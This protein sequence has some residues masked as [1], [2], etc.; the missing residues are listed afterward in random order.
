MSIYAKYS[1]AE[2]LDVLKLLNFDKFFIQNYRD[3]S[4]MENNF[5]FINF[6]I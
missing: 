1:R 2:I 4:K 5:S 3:S 6:Q